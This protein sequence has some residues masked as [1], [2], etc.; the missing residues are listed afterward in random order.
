MSNDL[1]IILN[2]YTLL[3]G[4]YNEK[5]NFIDIKYIIKVKRYFKLNYIKFSKD[6]LY[7]IN[8]YIIKKYKIL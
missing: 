5:F 2:L 3:I 1:Q 7:I 6:F 8:E 4:F